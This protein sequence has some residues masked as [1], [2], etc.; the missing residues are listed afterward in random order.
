MRA[1]LEGRFE[2]VESAIQE[3]NAF[4]K[5]AWGATRSDLSRIFEGMLREQVCLPR[6]DEIADI[7][8]IVSEA[9]G[10]TYGSYRIGLVRRYVQAGRLEDARRELTRIAAND[11]SDIPR[12]WVWLYTMS[13]LAEIA[14][15]FDGER[16]RNALYDYL[17]PY[18]DRCVMAGALFCTGSVS[19][20][21]GV[22]AS[23][24]GRF[25]DAE[26]HFEAALEMNTRIRSRVWVAHTEHDYARMLVARGA[27][28]DR[29]KAAGLLE[30][31]LAT[32]RETGMKVLEQ[33]IL[34]T[35]AE[36]GLAVA[37]KL[38]PAP[39]PVVVES[40]FEREG[41]FWVIAWEGRSLRLRD[42]KGLQYLA[43]LIRGE[44]QEIHATDLAAGPADPSTEAVRD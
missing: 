38:P 7:E 12:E 2:G 35:L 22:L 33:T 10:F 13:R 24:M 4:G 32:T 11:F 34:A 28:G 5:E 31:A 37:E 26:K 41:D 27:A 16:P 3:V 18:A 43:A 6:P 9:G 42:S 44:G 23:L 20:P 39:A 25:E 30:S 8:A 40:R 21:L 29:E 17:L 36:T 1:T 15:L 14:F 19:R